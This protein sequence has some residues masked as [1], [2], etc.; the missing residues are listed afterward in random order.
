MSRPFRFRPA[1][2]NGWRTGAIRAAAILLACSGGAGSAEAARSPW[3]S[4]P[5]GRLRVMLVRAEGRVKGGIEIALEPGWHTY[6]RNPGDA[7]VPPR[8][9]FDG[10]RNVGAVHVHFPAPE[11]FDDGTSVSA[12]Y[13]DSVVFPLEIRP[14]A[15]GP[16]T[17][18]LRA[19]LGVC[20]EICIPTEAEAEVT[21]KPQDGP[22]ALSEAKLE[23]F[24]RL[25]PGA[26]EPGR[27]EVKEAAVAGDAVTV[28]LI[29]PPDAEPEL[30]VDAPPDWLLGQ[31]RLVAHEG[32]LARYR[33]SLKGRPD[34]P[35]EALRFVATAGGRAIE[36]TVVLP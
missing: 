28:S 36:E 14:E 2:V 35:G 6:W 18:S 21:L 4:I 19:M 13:H 30:F 9:D 33:L 22:D 8:F 25:L 24:E 23:M 32:A 10:S 34:T 15:D 1:G 11:R 17:L 27:F 20:R 7:G 5:E 12:V 31:P 26:P 16:I 3:V 29:A